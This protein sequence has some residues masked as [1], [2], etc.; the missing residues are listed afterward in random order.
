MHATWNNVQHGGFPHP[1]EKK[2]LFFRVEVVYDLA[3]ECYY[4]VDIT[5]NQ[6]LTEPERLVKCHRD[7]FIWAFQT[8]GSNHQ[9]GNLYIYCYLCLG[10]IWFDFEWDQQLYLVHWNIYY[11]ISLRIVISHFVHQFFIGLI[12]TIWIKWSGIWIFIGEAS[13]LPVL[14]TNVMCLANSV[15]YGWRVMIFCCKFQNYE[16]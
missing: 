5:V 13:S 12:M 15:F 7:C 14:F 11:N 10:L 2:I 8:T 16:A 9:Q 3:Y 1:F 6:I 4:C